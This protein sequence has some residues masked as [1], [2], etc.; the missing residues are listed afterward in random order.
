MMA[1]RKSAAFLLPGMFLFIGLTVWLFRSPNDYPVIVMVFLAFVL[2]TG[3][4]I[5]LEIASVFAVLITLIE[6]GVV[7]FVRGADKGYAAGQFVL[8]WAGLY[9]ANRY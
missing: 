2:A 9:L 6:L 1:Q 7:G 8:M 5:S 3:F 4:A